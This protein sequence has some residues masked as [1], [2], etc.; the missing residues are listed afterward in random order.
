[1]LPPGRAG[2]VMDRNPHAFGADENAHP[3]F[4]G[5]QILFSVW[6][7]FGERKWSTFARADDSAKLRLLM[8]VHP[9]AFKGGAWLTTVY[10]CS[11]G[12]LPTSI[13]YAFSYGSAVLISLAALG[14]VLILP[15][16]ANSLFFCSSKLG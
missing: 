7:A 14:I 3:F 10:Q 5:R 11:F 13:R 9:W 16:T 4:A 2:L 12:G 15:Y 6:V 8:L 1:M